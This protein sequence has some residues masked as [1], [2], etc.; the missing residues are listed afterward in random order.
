MECFGAPRPG[1]DWSIQTKRAGRQLLITRAIGEAISGTLYLLVTVW[2]LSRAHTC[3]R[4]LVSVP[5]N[6]LA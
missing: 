6:K 4:G 2:L 3:K 1:P 5:A